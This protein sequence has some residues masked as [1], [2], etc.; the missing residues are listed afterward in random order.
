M[1]DQSP[2]L[3][4]PDCACDSEG[5]HNSG[6]LNTL[7]DTAFLPLFLNPRYIQNPLTMISPFPKAN[8]LFEI[9]HLA[10]NI[11]NIHV[12]SD[13]PTSIP[14]ILLLAILIHSTTP[15][16]DDA[17]LVLATVPIIPSLVVNAPAWR[18]WPSFALGLCFSI[19]YSRQAQVP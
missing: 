19:M 3:A 13:K 16:P 11:P 2:D 7:T 12:L 8:K 9:S 6:Q 18:F 4:S 1:L 14:H 17:Q 5:L 10:D 15:S